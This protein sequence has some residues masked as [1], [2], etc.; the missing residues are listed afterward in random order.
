MEWTTQ[1]YD[2]RLY[3]K[4]KF[5][6]NKLKVIHGLFMFEHVETLIKK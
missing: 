2:V 4:F 5:M 1:E 3:L 6:L